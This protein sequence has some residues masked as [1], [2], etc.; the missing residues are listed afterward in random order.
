MSNS[1]NLEIISISSDDTFTSNDFTELFPEFFPPNTHNTPANTPANTPIKTTPNY[2]FPPDNKLL[3]P[4]ELDSAEDYFNKKFPINES[5]LPSPIPVVKSL[6]KPLAGS[7]QIGVKTP[8]RRKFPFNNSPSFHL[9]FPNQTFESP[10]QSESDIL[11]ANDLSRLMNGSYN[12]PTDILSPTQST[13]SSLIRRPTIKNPLTVTKRIPNYIK[14]KTFRGKPDL[15]RRR[16]VNVA[17]KPAPKIAGKPD[18]RKM[19]QVI[20]KATPKPK[21]KAAPKTKQQ[22]TSTQME[23][24]KRKKYEYN[25]QY[26]LKNKDIIN[27]KR[28]ERRA[29]KAA[30]KATPKRKS[31]LPKFFQYPND[32]PMSPKP[33][34]AN[35]INPHL[36]SIQKLF[37]KDLPK[38]KIP[39]KKTEEDKEEDKEITDIDDVDID[40]SDFD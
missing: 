31:H 36:V 20:T 24:K 18:W 2:D 5:L 3:V 29:K 19:Q 26:R 25:R 27:Q 6:F 22:P 12:A 37:H 1:E 28:Q 9:N 32:R 23:E 30:T 11:R 38:S 14:T 16:S 8:T 4:L 21:P 33:R 17:R 7:T 35:N 40:D 15:L 13:Q 39:K 10:S 34:R